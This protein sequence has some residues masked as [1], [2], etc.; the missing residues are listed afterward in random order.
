MSPDLAHYLRRTAPRYTSYPTAP[1]FNADVDGAVYGDWLEALHPGRSLSLY[2]HVPFCRRGWWY[3]GCNMKLASRYDPIATYV[4][5]LIAELVLGAERLPARFALSHIHWGGGTPT[6]LEPDDLERVMDA[7]RA[8]FNLTPDVELAIESDPRTLTAEMTARIGRLGFNRA[9][10]G[11]Q[12]FDPQV[13]TA[14]NRVQ[15]PD[16]VRQ[17]VDGLREAGVTGINFDLIY[18]LPHQT[19]DTLNHTIELC[20]D[21]APDRIALFGYAHVPWMAKK[22][23]MIDEA[24]LPDA[25]ARLDQAFG[26]AARLKSAGYAAIGLDHFALPHDALAQAARAGSLKRNFQGYTTDDA[27]ALIGVGA[28]AIGRLPQGY[29]QNY[30]ETGAWART[31]EA[32][33]LPTAKGR[34]FVGE[35]RLRGAVIEALM[36]SGAADLS[37]LAAQYGARPDWGRPELNRLKP[38]VQDG[39]V[40]IA[41]HRIHLT[42]QGEQF[43]RLVASAFDEYLPKAQARHSVAV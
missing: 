7:V 18:G 15:P 31:V 35:D 26:A 3:F 12:E 39:L 23:R 36:C 6:A 11:V 2:L 8:R 17:A 34:A 14:I 30:G 4:G 24:T 20:A 21:M 37:A 33:R 1:H 27:E 22:Q 9:S 13:Q 5:Q 42:P 10:F 28:T 29:T 38:L 41:G 25:A 43:A 40:V 16:M 19:V 32:G